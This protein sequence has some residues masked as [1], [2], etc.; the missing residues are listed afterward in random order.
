MPTIYLYPSL[1]NARSHPYLKQ[2][3]LV[4]GLIF[5]FY[6]ISKGTE[7]SY[8]KVICQGQLHPKSLSITAVSWLCPYGVRNERG[9]YS[10]S[11]ATAPGPAR[12]EEKCLQF[13]WLLEFSSGLLTHAL[14]TLG[15]VNSV[16]SVN[17]KTVGVRNRIWHWLFLSKKMMSVHFAHIHFPY[18]L[19]IYG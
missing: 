2:D 1:L 11:V 5:H 13:L 10:G 19:F 12:K 4:P 16:D 15:S 9:G 6:Q 17:S 8:A 3:C 14:P 7:I 18:V